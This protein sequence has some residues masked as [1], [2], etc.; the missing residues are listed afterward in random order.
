MLA[1]G[2]GLMLQHFSFGL[3][4]VNLSYDFLLV[5]R[6]DRVADEAALVY[7]DEKSHLA[8][9]QSFTA[10]WDRRLHARLIER[11]TEAG[12]RG[13]VF[14]IVFSDPNPEDPAADELLARATRENGTVVLAA[15]RVL[16][17]PGRSETIPP[18]DLLLD[19]A[20]G[21]GS[22]E[23]VPGRDLVVR[24]HTPG[25]E[26]PSLAWAA[27]EAVGAAPILPPGPERTR[28]INYYG[29]PNWLPSMSYVDALVS[30]TNVDALLH[31]KVVFV[32]ARI[33]TKFA[34]E[35]KD[36]Y[37]NP[38]S[39][40][41]SRSQAEAR[42]GLFISGV[43]IQATTFL[44]LL[45]KDWLTRTPPGTESMCLI[46]AGILAGWG[47]VQLR[48]IPASL[49]ALAGLVALV[50]CSYLLF[51]VEL[52]WFPWLFVVV[53]ILVVLGWSVLFNSVQLYVQK[54]LYE[55][56]LA[57]YLSPKL[58]KKFSGNPALLKPGAEKQVLT[59]FFS[60]IEDFT[61]LSEGMDSDELASLM[62]QYFESA[63]S[64]C[65][66]RTEGTVVKYI[67]D[68]IFAFWSAPE[69]QTD[70]AVRACEAALRFRDLAAQ[71]ID[72]RH[73][74]TRIGLHTGLANVGNFGS[75]QRVDYTALGENVNLASR[76]EGLNKFLGTSCV[77]T[78]DTRTA[79]GDR[80]VTRDLGRFR[81][82]GFEKV[83]AV[84]ELVGWPEEAE[85]TRAW[86][87]VF[88]E[89]LLAYRRRDFDTAQRHFLR[90]IE[91]RPEDGPSAFYLKRIQDIEGQAQL[92]HWNGDIGLTEK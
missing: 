12:V 51:R 38:F 60:D 9:G 18:F 19:A 20:A 3:G 65:I 39:Q 36:E 61:R 66:H 45:R 43:E 6:G 31:D 34:G 50:G 27:A 11:L 54:Q 53:Q 59:L 76:M 73:L 84:H 7:L 79:I 1:V 5:A 67:G 22:A 15:D 23:V 85:L 46:L 69:V 89:A 68:A 77:M 57:L 74:R 55:N 32:G 47:L 35:R 40:W 87:T 25:A 81:L 56:T 37:R 16:I 4:L 41:V 29:P 82:K 13:I 17:A 28:W 8:L 21:V 44:N 83:V 75:A 52:I 24:Q 88:R 92:T 71:A 14:D 49:A 63:V 70:H 72:D 2:V 26:L 91:L 86:R 48:P 58:V 78:G 42:G 64:K 10:P 62:N 90:T 30:D 33:M 80:F